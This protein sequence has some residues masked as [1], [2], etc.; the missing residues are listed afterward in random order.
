M[1]ALQFGASTSS[2]W[3]IFSSIG[4]EPEG[5]GFGALVFIRLPKIALSLLLVSLGINIVV[6]N[7]REEL[8][9]AASGTDN[10]NVRR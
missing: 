6:G 9:E 3:G 8:N 5:V 1:K 4:F 7:V 10:N 2:G